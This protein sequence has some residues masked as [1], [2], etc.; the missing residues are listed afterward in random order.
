MI[1]KN[2]LTNDYLLDNGQKYNLND[3]NNLS[4]NFFKDKIEEL[5][6]LY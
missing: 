4:A 1:D 6:N 5:V 3:A 2:V